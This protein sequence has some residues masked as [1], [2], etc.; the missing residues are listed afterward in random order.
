MPN[1]RVGWAAGLVVTTLLAAAPAQEKPTY[2]L[3]SECAWRAGDVTTVTKRDERR[4]EVYIEA[5]DRVVHDRVSHEVV[6]T[7]AVRQVLE[8]DEDGHATRYLLYF[9]EWTR[10]LDDEKRTDLQ[11]AFIE[12]SGRG[13]E[14]SWTARSDSSSWSSATRDWVSKQFGPG[15]SEAGAFGRKMVPGRPVSVGDEWTP[16]VSGLIGAL[17]ASDARYV[18]ATARLDRVGELDGGRVGWID[19]TIELPVPTPPGVEVEWT[20]G[21]VMDVSATGTVPLDE[22][23]LAEDGRARMETRCVGVVR[24]DGVAMDLTMTL[25]FALEFERRTGGEMPPLSEEKEPA[26]GE[27]AE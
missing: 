9:E 25:A 22:R 19:L 21:G 6:E 20:E 4:Q 27:E 10:T 3:L 13:D 12:V 1:A 24:R 18:E 16:E 14:R 15:R 2:E 8:T 5:G 11:G 23:A 17:G 7:K 26:E